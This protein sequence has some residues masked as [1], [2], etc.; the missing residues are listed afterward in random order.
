MDK[1]K[2]EA[3][4]IWDAF[5]R[6]TENIHVAFRKKIQ[7]SRIQEISEIRIYC[8]CSG[9]Y[10]LFINGSLIGRGSVPASTGYQYYNEYVLNE[11]RIGEIVTCENIISV[12]A[13]S[14]GTGIQNRGFSPAG[15]LFQADIIYANGIIDHVC[16]DS[17]WRISILECWVQS[18]P[19]MFWTIGW[20][21]IVDLRKYD[22]RILDYN[23]DDMVWGEK[24]NNINN[25][26]PTV[27]MSDAWDHAV[28]ICSANI[29]TSEKLIPREIPYL[30]ETPVFPARI[31][32]YGEC[33]INVLD[34]E[35]LNIADMMNIEEHKD[36]EN[37]EIAFCE[38]IDGPVLARRY[39]SDETG[40]IYITYDFGRELVGYPFVELTSNSKCLIDIGYS[41]CLDDRNRVDC[42]RQDIRQ[43][44][45]LIVGAGKNRWEFFGRRAFRYLQL[46]V[47]NLKTNISID[48]IG[49]IELQYPFIQEG[50][51]KCSNSMINNIYNV[52]K[53]T[54][55]VCMKES[56]EDCPLREKAQYIGDLRVGALMN[57]YAFGDILLVSKGLRQFAMEQRSDGWFKSISPGSTDHNIVDYLPVWVMAVWDYYVYTGDND[58]LNDVYENIKKLLQ[59]LGS[60]ANHDGLLE[61]RPEWWIF[62]DWGNT[63][64]NGIVT[65]LQCVY[66]KSLVDAA[67][68]AHVLGL[69]D[70]RIYFLEKAFVVKK[71]INKYLWSETEGAFCD[72]V[73]SFNN[74]KSGLS[75]QTNCFAVLFDI[76]DDRKKHAIR[77]FI[78]ERR[79]QPIKTGYFKLYELDALFKLGLYKE[80]LDGFKFWEGMIILGAT[81]F[82]ETFD[83]TELKIP[84]VSL[85]H[86]WSAAPLYLL[87]SRILGV[88]PRKPGFKKFEIRPRIMGFDRIEGSIPTKYGSIVVIFQRIDGGASLVCE[89]PAGTQATIL[90]PF[91]K[92]NSGMDIYLNNQ[93]DCEWAFRDGF[94][95]REVHCGGKYEFCFPFFK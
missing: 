46:T 64:K 67:N 56:Y 92:N 57:Y 40:S 13:Y 51:F 9:E 29:Q 4:W 88:V 90:I 12:F 50:S 78:S 8:A 15:F 44:D 62:L 37:Y 61:K 58:F 84:D 81:T 69:N 93:I 43:A 73:Q 91:D 94:F 72:C 42:T 41:E 19:R 31:I 89:I 87:P 74:E 3:Y 70:D 55:R 54:L 60:H 77:N 6:F 49:L 27:F 5:H 35:I 63:K 83:L 66:Y 34:L 59:W 1:I 85:C 80:F 45:R 24:A 95:E 18:S 21:E 10:K 22:S 25:I 32:E 30:T 65:G 53:Y 38:N 48:N 76:A 33:T 7:L 75:I 52:S 11:S 71:S 86:G 17:T 82:W 26:D 39:N 68:I 28:E 47:R 23:Y 36:L 16:S 20:Q 14:Y 79:Y 2:W